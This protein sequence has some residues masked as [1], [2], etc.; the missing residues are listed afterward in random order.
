VSIT[1]LVRAMGDVL[2]FVGSIAALLVTV[3][4]ARKL[5]KGQ[6]IAKRRSPD[7]DSSSEPR[8][9]RRRDDDAA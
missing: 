7:H 2:S 6:F 4:A 8:P 1:E 5:P 9:V 3:H